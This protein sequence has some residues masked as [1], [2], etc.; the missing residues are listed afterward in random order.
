M[1]QRTPGAAE[2]DMRPMKMHNLFRIRDVA[3]ESLIPCKS[4]WEPPCLVNTSCIH[5]AARETIKRVGSREGK[6]FE[7]LSLATIAAYKFIVIVHRQ[8]ASLT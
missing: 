6:D 8:D 5:T 2:G 4:L 7:V 1:P 3:R